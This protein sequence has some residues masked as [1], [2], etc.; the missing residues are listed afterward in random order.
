MAGL[1]TI[2]GGKEEDVATAESTAAAA[3]ATQAAPGAGKQLIVTG[4]SISQSGTAPAAGSY[5]AQ[6]RENASTVRRNFRLPAAAFAPII[7]E[8]KRPLFIT[9]NLSADITVGSMGAG[10][11]IRVEL[12]TITRYV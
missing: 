7:Y 12:I 2:L 11:V 6:I 4:F 1:E 8:F 3:T 5:V 10:C 9:E